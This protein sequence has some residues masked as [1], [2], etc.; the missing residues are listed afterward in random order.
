MKTKLLTITVISILISSCA[1]TGIIGSGNGISESRE[2]GDYTSVKL[3][4]AADVNITVGESNTFS[5]SGDDN[6]IDLVTTK[7]EDGQLVIDQSSQ[8][9]TNIG[10]IITISIPSISSIELDGAGDIDVTGVNT[11][12][13]K[14]DL[15]GAGDI[16]VSGTTDHLDAELDGA[17]DMNLYSLISTTAKVEV[18]GAGSIKVYAT[19]TLDATINGAG[20]I[21]YKGSC[22]LINSEVN[23]AGDI[24]SKN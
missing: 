20:D 22:R 7:I 19:E 5:I 11:P 15:D 4:T 14:I 3:K 1:L 9:H 6:I 23:G 16:S 2:L 24:I 21:K 8:F 17:G 12:N 18:D 10:V 13:M